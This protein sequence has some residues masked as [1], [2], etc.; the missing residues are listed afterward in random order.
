MKQYLVFINDGHFDSD[1]L[2]IILSQNKGRLKEE[3]NKN[4]A[5]FMKYTGDLII[6]IKR[7]DH[8]AIVQVMDAI[9]LLLMKSLL[10]LS[11]NGSERMEKG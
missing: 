3:L 5:Q 2:V 4:I 1:F 7:E 11:K 8:M 10:L 6:S 9:R